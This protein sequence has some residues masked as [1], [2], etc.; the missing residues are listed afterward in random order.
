MS[1]NRAEVTEQQVQEDLMRL[2]AYRNQLNGLLQ[3]YQILTSSRTDHLRARESLEGVDRADPGAEFLLPLGGETFVRGSVAVGAPVLIGI[4]SGY[5]V[6]M[7]RAK[8]SELLAERLARIDQAAREVEGQM[9]TLDERIQILSRRLDDI[10][11]S[12]PGSDVGG[13]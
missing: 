3:Q 2:D 11:R 13:A 1:G 6:E 7:N 12:G 9:A 5:V 4:G 8:A 10:A